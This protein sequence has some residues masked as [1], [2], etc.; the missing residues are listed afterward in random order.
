[1]PEE[2]LF[3]S[4]I[5]SNFTKNVKQLASPV[6]NVKQLASPVTAVGVVK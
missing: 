3:D 1:M 4:S 6:V 5:L 2:S